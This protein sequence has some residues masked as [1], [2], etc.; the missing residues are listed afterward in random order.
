MGTAIYPKHI[1]EPRVDD[2]T[3]ASTWDIDTDPAAVIGTGPFTIERWDRGERLVL[4]RNPNY[5]LRDGAGNRLPYLDRVIYEIVP[6]IA[7]ELAKFQAGETDVHG[8]P[9]EEFAILEPLQ[10]EGNF[11]IHR[12]GPAFGTT[13]LAFNMNPGSDPETGEP[14]LA[15]EKLEWFRNPQFRRAVAHSVDKAAIIREIQDGLGYPQWSSISPAAGDFHNPDVQPLRVRHRRGQCDPRRSRLDGSRRGWDP[16][17]RRRQ[18]DR[19]LARDQQRQHRA[20][21]GHPA[22]AGGAGADRRP[23]ELRAARLRRSR[24]PADLLLRLGGDGDRI[25]RR[26]GPVRRHQLLAQQRD[27]CTCGTRN[28]RSPRRNGKLRSTISTSG[29]PRSWITTSEWRSTTGP[30]RS[31]PSKCRSSTRRSPSG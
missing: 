18:R 11:T 2:G 4:R 21:N 17:G 7:A 8:M 25:H 3:F 19:V 9:G 24:L 28:S 22:V 14:Y 30:R 5:W 20:R 1:L 27:P 26:I 13:F 15:A 23:G 31:L 6:D 16:R 29:P 12:R 10:D